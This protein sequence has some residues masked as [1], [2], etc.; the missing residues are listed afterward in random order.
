[1]T[2][3]KITNNSDANGSAAEDPIELPQ[4][5]SKS[6]LR[7]RADPTRMDLAINSHIDRLIS[8][9]MDFGLGG[10]LE[11][12]FVE[13]AEA[14]HALYRKHEAARMQSLNTLYDQ[15]GRPDD[16]IVVLYCKNF[17]PLFENWLASCDKHTIA[18]RKKVLAFTLDEESYEQTRVLG[19]STYFLNPDIY[20]Q[21]GGSANYSDR[22]FARTMFYKNAIVN[23]VLKLGAS[24]LF[25]DVDMLW[26]RDPFDYFSAQGKDHDLYI[27]YDG[28]NPLHRPLYANSGFI[29]ARCNDACKALFETAFRNTASIFQC[30]SHQKP[31]NQILAFFAVHNVLA[32]KVLPEAVFLNGH[33]FDLKQGVREK[34]GD[35]ERDAYVVHYSWTANREEK[36]QKIRK[37]GFNYLPGETLFM[38]LNTV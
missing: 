30:R 18:V 9:E 11:R 25:Q 26:L 31:L 1:M 2:S 20:M 3:A 6:A 24:V 15:L 16:V 17:F 35:W 23:D 7:L 29:Y 32:I 12:N 19:I 38:Q 27:M 37:F 8:K 22:E 34:A 28:P 14:C 33:L 36:Q 4:Q 13:L 10:A 21:G 5:V